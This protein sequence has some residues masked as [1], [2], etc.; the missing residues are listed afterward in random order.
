[1]AIV[2]RVERYDDREQVIVATG[3]PDG[4]RVRGGSI[5]LDV[6][7]APRTLWRTEIR[8]CQGESPV[9]PKRD[10]VPSRRDSFVVTSLALAF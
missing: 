5:G 4:F 10:S 2:G 7:S 1:M 8:G 9:F 3:L 6:V